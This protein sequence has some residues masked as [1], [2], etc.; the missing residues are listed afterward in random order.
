MYCTVISSLEPVK[1]ATVNVG[2]SVSYPLIKPGYCP[3]AYSDDNNISPNSSYA[4]DV[5]VI[6]PVTKVVSTSNVIVVGGNGLAGADAES[7]EKYKLFGVSVISLLK[8]FK[9]PPSNVLVSSTN[10]GM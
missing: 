6:E 3:P 9:L 4:P 1:S 2:D 8:R 10:I 5:Y 7:N